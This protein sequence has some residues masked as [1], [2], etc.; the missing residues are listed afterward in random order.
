MGLTLVYEE[1]VHT[2]QLSFTNLNCLSFKKNRRKLY[3]LDW[4]SAK[5]T[6]SLSY[7]L[8]VCY[9]AGWVLFFFFN[10]LV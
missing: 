4:L 3:H 6:A 10:L 8:Y 2:G 1:K 7:V 5:T 9:Q